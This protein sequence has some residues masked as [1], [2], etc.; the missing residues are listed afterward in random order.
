VM[1]AEQGESIEQLMQRR[2]SDE[3]RASPRC[4]SGK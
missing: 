1:S 3:H 4:L 2:M